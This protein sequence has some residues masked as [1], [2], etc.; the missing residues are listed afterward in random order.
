MGS[1]MCI[2]DRGGW[3][4]IA[5]K[6]YACTT[7]PFAVPMGRPLMENKKYGRAGD[8]ANGVQRFGRYTS[9]FMPPP[10]KRTPGQSVKVPVWA[11]LD[12][13]L[14]PG[15]RTTI[16]CTTGTLFS[17]SSGTLKIRTAAVGSDIGDEEEVHPSVYQI[18]SIDGQ[19]KDIIMTNDSP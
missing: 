7:I 18:I 8:S 15:V 2:R 4:N 13:M 12:T 5:E 16:P 3:V 10:A 11:V 17:R 6:F 14:Q 1:E 9:P 19:A